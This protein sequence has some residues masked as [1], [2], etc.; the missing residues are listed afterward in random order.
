MRILYVFPEPLPLPRARG[1]QVA[2]TVAALAREGVTVRFAYVPADDDA[3]PL[4]AYGINRPRDVEHV[5]LSRGLS[6]PF[7][8][9]PLRSNRLFFRR[10]ACWI[11]RETNQGHRP[12]LVMARHLKL[13]E[14]LLDRFPGIPLLYEVHEVYAD[15]APASK[16]ARYGAIEAHIVQSAAA[17]VT[18]SRATL[19]RLIELYGRRDH[20]EVVPN[21]VDWPAHL[22]EK[23]WS[24]A[25]HH[26][27]YAGSLFAWKGVADLIAAAE[28]LPR[29]RITLIGGDKEQIERLR[30]STPT[31]G[32]EIEFT[33]RL[34]HQQVLARLAGACIAV[35]PNRADPDSA[36]TSPIKLFEYMAAG[37]A[38]VATDLPSVRE[39]LAENEA[40]WVPPSNPERLAAGIRLLANDPEQAQQ[41]GERLHERARAYTWEKRASRLAEIMR[42]LTS[43]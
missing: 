39:V 12:S 21:G 24:D 33:G 25:Q 28:F 1:V 30:A 34:P 6:A 35:L 37:C 40:I 14:M 7:S 2:H 19:N 32:A 8:W 15:T 38:V 27:V 18:N 13:G 23:P 26:V 9:L 36:F 16:R 10:L 29:Y 3:D 22:T 5:P 4:A 11:E 42:T 20:M 17:I 43:V 31:K 41:L